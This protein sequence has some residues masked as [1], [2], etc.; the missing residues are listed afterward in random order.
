M[1][2]KRTIRRS[3]S[4][5]LH[6]FWLCFV[7][8]YGSFW[9]VI[10][11]NIQFE[12]LFATMLCKLL[13]ET[14]YLSERL[15]IFILFSSKTAPPNLLSP[16]GKPSIVGNND[17]VIISAALLGRVNGMTEW[18]KVFGLIGVISM[19]SV[20]EVS[21]DGRSNRSTSTF[22]VFCSNGTANVSDGML[23]SQL[24]NDKSESLNPTD[25][26]NSLENVIS[27][28][29]VSGVPVAFAWQ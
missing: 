28:L 11:N 8:K 2:S 5:S 15:N 27:W 13:P 12:K 14:I 17:R 3:R 18:G 10:F 23:C 7:L 4:S 16:I 25:P 29:E 20:H 1:N 24:S 9:K 22:N 6:L 26:S 21:N 19:C